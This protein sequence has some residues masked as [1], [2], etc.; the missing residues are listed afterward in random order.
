MEKTNR[1]GENLIEV[2]ARTL[3][4]EY[5]EYCVDNDDKRMN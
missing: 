4:K 3:N 1:N 5:F 2:F